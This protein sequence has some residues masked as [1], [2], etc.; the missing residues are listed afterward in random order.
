MQSNRFDGFCA[1]CSAQV[2]A[3][4]GS[5]TGRPGQWRTW[6]LACSPRPPAR[7][8]HDGWHRVPLASL[9]FETTGIDPLHDR[10]VSYAL[11]GEPGFEIVGLVDPGIPVPAASAAVHGLTDE[12]L[13]SAPGSAEAIAV[14]ADWVQT[15]VERGVGLV[16]FNAS[17][18]LTML[19]AECRR[20]GIVEPD[21]QRL[22]VVD[23]FVVDWGI[24][25]GHL[26]R[27]RLTDVASYYGVA[28]EDAH[29]ATADARAARDVAVELASR[30]AHVGALDLLE[31]MERQRGW[32]A[33]R[34]EDWNAYAR[35]KGRDL[36]DPTAWP[37]A[38]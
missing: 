18:D 12:M 24:E 31:L 37:L 14:V 38:G 4:G 15:L 21:W 17:Y 6:C 25:R 2:L 30:H 20:H 3:G 27:R 19:R 33:D 7:G 11:L 23:P 36:D 35:T 13:A 28:L 8:D 22:L 1:A 32:Y 29:D 5:L 9:D 10:V 34:A 26:G 16:V